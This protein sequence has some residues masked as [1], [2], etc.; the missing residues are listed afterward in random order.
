MPYRNVHMD[1]VGERES[2]NYESLFEH[3]LPVFRLKIGKYY[4]CQFYLGVMVMFESRYPDIIL[5]V[6][7][8]SVGTFMCNER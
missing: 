4:G 1:T 3:N 6:L 8:T 2:A 7:H 5:V